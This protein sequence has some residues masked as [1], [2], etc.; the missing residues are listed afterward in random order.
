MTESSLPNLTRPKSTAEKSADE[1]NQDLQIDVAFNDFFRV[2]A[3][4]ALMAQ[5][6]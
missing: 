5:L 6:N 2:I 4:L 1:G 3:F